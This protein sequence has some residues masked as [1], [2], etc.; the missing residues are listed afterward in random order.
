MM[1]MQLHR[2]CSRRCDAESTAVPKTPSAV[3]LLLQLFYE[4]FHC[5]KRNGSFDPSISDS[6]RCNNSQRRC[7][8]MSLW[9]SS[10]DSSVTFCSPPRVQKHRFSYLYLSPRANEEPALVQ[11]SGH[12]GRLTTRAASQTAMHA[13]SHPVLLQEQILELN[14]AVA[15]AGRCMRLFSHAVSN[16]LLTVID[17]HY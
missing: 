5:P 3:G 1:R 8:F 13:H 7:A 17:L 12:K 14:R 6:N 11:R 16:C 2:L 10:H 4:P 15:C 9:P